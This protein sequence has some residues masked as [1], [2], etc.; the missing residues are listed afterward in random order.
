MKFNETSAFFDQLRQNTVDTKH[1]IPDSIKISFD[2][3]G[4]LT[5]RQR[6]WL[7]NNWS[8]QNGNIEVPK[9]I[10]KILYD[11]EFEDEQANPGCKFYVEDGVMFQRTTMHLDPVK[12]ESVGVNIILANLFDKIAHELNQ[13]SVALRS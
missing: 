13:A 2:A 7:R 11:C 12:P 4:F 6:M 9:E 10:K 3:T 8:M 1:H 5:Q